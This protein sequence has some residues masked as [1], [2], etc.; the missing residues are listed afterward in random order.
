M[1]AAGVESHLSQGPAWSGHWP[2]PSCVMTQTQKADAISILQ[3]GFQ[4]HPGKLPLLSTY[5]LQNNLL[6]GAETQLNQPRAYP[7]E[8]CKSGLRR[9]D[10][11]HS[12]SS[13][14]LLPDPLF[15][16]LQPW[17]RS[18][19]L[20]CLPQQCRQ[21]EALTQQDLGVTGEGAK[22]HVVW[23]RAFLSHSCR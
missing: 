16:S 18:S 5:S 23:R 4:E 11:G 10:R 9:V 12:W 13:K 1:K 19:C 22:M 8:T 20:L 3:T 7:P 21:L 15:P 2:F 14:M 6:G 17:L